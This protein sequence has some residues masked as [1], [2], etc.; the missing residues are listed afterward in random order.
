M[1][2]GGSKE[3]QA[4]REG[5]FQPRENQGPDTETRVQYPEPTTLGGQV[6]K[7]SSG[8]EVSQNGAREKIEM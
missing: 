5:K 4:F 1:A 2:Q 8:S 3:S 6:G 7:Q